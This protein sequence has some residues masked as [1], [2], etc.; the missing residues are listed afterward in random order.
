MT[1]RWRWLLVQFANQ[2]WLRVALFAV[3]AALTAAAGVVLAP[4]VPGEWTVQIGAKAIDGI[5]GILA[6]SMLAVTVFS[7]S[8]MVTAYGAATTNV[9]PRAA[10]LL[11]EDN[12]SKNVLGTLIGAFLFSLVGIIAL[13]TGAYGDQGRTILLAVTILLIVLIAVTL[14]RWID[15]LSRF[16][17]TGE[18]LQRVEE[19]TRRALEARSAHPYMGGRRFDDVG[20]GVPAQAKTV[21]AGA[22]GY[23]QH[24]DSEALQSFAQQHGGQVFINALPGIFADAA[25][26]IALFSGPAFD[27]PEAALAAIRKAFTIGTERTYEQDPRFGLCVL[28]EIASRALSPAVND[29][30][31]AIDV[32]GRGVRLLSQWAES[33]QRAV[34]D[35]VACPLVWVPAIGVDDMFDDIFA[36]IARDG[37]GLLEVQMRLQKAFRALCAAGGGELG[38]AALRHSATAL[39]RAESELRLDGEKTVVRGLAVGVGG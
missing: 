8:A 30:G 19:A 22:I 27:D 3:V 9:T 32:I 36:P 26:P 14:L 17:R 13:S 31:T 10:R 37:A 34:A 23:V 15:Y 39:A 33:Q 16:G 25:R 24:I 11:I 5:L 1:S 18:V 6:S 2:L 35:G 12:T 4:F 38:A 20:H 29:P 21:F 28:A 7:V